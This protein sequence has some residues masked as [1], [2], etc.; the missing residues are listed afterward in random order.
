MLRVSSE[1]EADHRRG[2]GALGIGD[3]WAD[4]AVASM[5]T[6]WNYGPGYEDLLIEAYGLTPARDRLAYYR[7]LWDAT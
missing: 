3:R 5:S 4:I 7:E 1:G 6:V 2:W